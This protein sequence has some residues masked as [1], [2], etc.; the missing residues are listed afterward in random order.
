MEST[1]VW[2]I[3]LVEEI[4]TVL[5]FAIPAR[6]IHKLVLR[7]REDERCTGQPQE[8]ELLTVS[9]RVNLS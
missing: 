1:T 6:M 2:P 3:L 8:F 4:G 7:D 9:R 5:F